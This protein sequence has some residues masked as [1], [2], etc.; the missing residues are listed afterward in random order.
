MRVSWSV[1][2]EIVVLLNLKRGLR[3]RDYPISTVE[4]LSCEILAGF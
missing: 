1:E 4:L 3:Y 2:L